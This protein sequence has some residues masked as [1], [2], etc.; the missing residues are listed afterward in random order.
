M[1][2]KIF[3]NND[4][5]FTIV[6]MIS[7][8]NLHINVVTYIVVLNVYMQVFFILNFLKFCNAF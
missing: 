3:N 6:R 7:R 5:L 4:R 8:S 1:L 2:T